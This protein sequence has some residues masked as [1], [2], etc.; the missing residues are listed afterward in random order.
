MT[1]DKLRKV[2]LR[3]GDEGFGKAYRYING[4]K[5]PPIGQGSAANRFLYAEAITSAD[6]VALRG[7]NR[8]VG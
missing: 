2:E 1:T 3:F 8:Q 4:Y 5:R 7:A 6:T